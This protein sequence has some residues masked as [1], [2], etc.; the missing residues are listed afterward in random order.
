MNRRLRACGAPIAQ[1]VIHPARARYPSRAR[2]PRTSAR[3]SSSRPDTFSMT[4]QRGRNSPTT[5]AMSGQSHRGSSWAIWRP[6][7]LTGWHG[8]PPQTRSGTGRPP[9]HPAQVRTSSCL[10]TSGQ[11]FASTF[12]HHGSISICPTTVIPARSRPRSSP[13]MPL[14]RDRTFMW[15]VPSLPSLTTT[16]PLRPASCGPPPAPGRGSRA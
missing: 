6:A 15:P 14:N 5:D 1:A 13:P 12:R 7:W 8:K 11:C 16:A 2:S 10:G 9:H 3:P 4:T